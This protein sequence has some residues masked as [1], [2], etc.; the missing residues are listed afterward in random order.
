MASK[1]T[2]LSGIRASHSSLHLGNLLGAIESMVQSQDDDSAVRYF[3]VADLHGITTKFDPKDIHKNRREVALDYLAAGIDPAKSNLFFQSD[4]PEHLELAYYLSSVVNVNRLKHLPSLK[5]KI[6]DEGNVETLALLSYPVL[7]AADILLYKANK[8][9]IGQDQ[10]YHIEVAR[11]VVVSMNTRYGTNFPLPDPVIDERRVIPS[12][13]GDGKMSKSKHESAIFL[14]DSKEEITRKIMKIS[15]DN[16]TGEVLP[17]SSS[18]TSLVFN[19]AEMFLGIEYRKKIE[20]SYMDRSLKYVVV[21]Q[22]LADAI[23]KKIEPIQRKRK[24]FEDNPS[25]VDEIVRTGANNARLVAHS[26]VREVREKMG[27]A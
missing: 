27:L 17:D 14:S 12:L 26:T 11:E 21:K 22:D 5:Q 4:V 8:V 24:Y 20:S 19:L 1:I 3:M 23:Y 25:I 2:I 13:S 9:P 16:V 7:M 6:K 10:I 18:P 15:T